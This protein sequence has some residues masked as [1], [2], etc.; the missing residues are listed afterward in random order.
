LSIGAVLKLH[1][2][3]YFKK[4][5]V[6]IRF[7]NEKTEIVKKFVAPVQ[8]FSLHFDQNSELVNNNPKQLP[9]LS[10]DVTSGGIGVS[11]SKNG[12]LLIW[13]TE[14]GQIRVKILQFFWSVNTNFS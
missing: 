14:N 6:Q 3:L 7:Q 12:S 11:S 4:K 1:F 5:S 9:V 13:L 8:K 10:L 2:K